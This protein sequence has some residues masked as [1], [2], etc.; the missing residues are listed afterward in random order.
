MRRAQPETVRE[1][2]NGVNRK[3]RRN[4]IMFK[5]LATQLKLAALLGLFAFNDAGTNGDEPPPAAPAAPAPVPPAPAAPGTDDAAVRKAAA[6]AAKDAAAKAT[7]DMLAALGVDSI[8]AAAKVIADKNAADDAAK[9]DLVKAQEAAAAAEARAVAAETA[10][11]NTAYQSLAQARLIAAGVKAQAAAK[12]VRLLDCAVD[13]DTETIDAA[14][15]QLRE[16]DP[17]L[18]PAVT[19]P[20]STDGPAGSNGTPPKPNPG[21]KTPADLANAL[22]DSRFGNQK[23]S[24]EEILAGIIP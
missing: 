6:K 8:D 22:Y 15:E 24:S 1:W 14:I 2:V 4:H 21:G 16:E 18:F 3:T 5:F 7:A 23:S 13:A 12:R 19:E 9:D 11:A 17:D 20:P 10:A